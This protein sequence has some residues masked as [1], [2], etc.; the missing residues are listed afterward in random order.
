MSLLMAFALLLFNTA[1]LDPASVAERVQSVYN[2]AEALRC[3]FIQLYRSGTTG[4]ITE[5][6]GEL[7]LKKPGKMRWDYKSPERKLYVS[8]GKTVYWYL[9]ADRQVTRM[10]LEEADQQQTQILFLTGRGELLRDFEVSAETFF[11]EIYEGSYLLRLVPK[12]EEEFDYIV[13]EV[14][15]SDFFVERMIVVDAFGN[16]TDYRFA[17]IRPAEIPDRDF[18]FTVPRG[19]EVFEGK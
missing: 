5:A 4:K 1:Q 13:L 6:R 8:D 14:N 7:L 10:S 12:R 18:E 17:N 16:S 3:D 15:P 9:P 11:E 19:V 2:Q